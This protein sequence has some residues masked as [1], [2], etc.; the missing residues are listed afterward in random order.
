MA[1]P[2]LRRAHLRQES[3]LRPRGRSLLRAR[4]RRKR[5]AGDLPRLARDLNP[6]IPAGEVSTLRE[7]V[8]ATTTEFR[9]TMWVFL[10]FAGG[11]LVLAPIGIYGLVS[12]S[13]AQRTY[14]IG[15]RVAVGATRTEILTLILRQGF[16]LAIAC[17]AAGVA[18]SFALTRFLARLLFGVA[19]TDAATFAAVCALLLAVAAL[20]SYIPAWRAANL[21]P[22]KSCGSNSSKPASS[23]AA[24]QQSCPSRHISLVKGSLCSLRW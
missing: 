13:V 23:Q 9:S 11:T 4:H 21:D 7:I 12:H 8:A 10:S 17:I 20:A 14:E 1:G 3:R 24:S 19:P 22:V 6:G 18:V 5:L 2:A 16:G 15:L